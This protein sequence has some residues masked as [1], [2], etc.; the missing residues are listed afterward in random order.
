MRKNKA[1]HL[2]HCQVCGRRQMLPNG[3]LAKHGYTVEYGWFNGTCYGSGN[4]PIELDFKLVEDSIA[5]TEIHIK[6]LEEKIKYWSTDTSPK[7]YCEV[8][9]Q[10]G[11]W[12]WQEVELVLYHK[13]NLT[14]PYFKFVNPLNNKEVEIPFLAVKT[15]PEAVAIFNE[16]YVKHLQR[17]VSS[18]K[19]YIESQKNRIENWH[20]KP[21]IPRD[22][23][24][25]NS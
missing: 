17:L 12:V 16:K 6:D 20:E 1:T 10:T 11:I 7:T 8:K 24:N 23:Q 18:L 4:L 25:D 19:N 14:H 15:L 2:G 21:L 9:G 5:R 13:P 3:Q 22:T